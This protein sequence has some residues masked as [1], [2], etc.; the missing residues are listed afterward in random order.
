[1]DQYEILE[2]AVLNCFLMKPE[3]LKE[4]KLK[5]RHFKKH[6]RFFSFINNFYNNFGNLDISL[7][8][9]VCIEPAKV[10]NYIG[11][12]IDTN[13]VSSRFNLYEN[14]MLLFYQDFN[15]IIEIHELEKKLYARK[16]S[17]EEFTEEFNKIIG[18]KNE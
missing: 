17:L 18:G 14:Q 13:S 4:T 1:M 7:M 5:E 12:I 16:I 9:S 15:A 6:R 8:S 2:R 10:F 3:L 11:N